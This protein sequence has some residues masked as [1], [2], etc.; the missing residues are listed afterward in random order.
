MTLFIAFC[1]VARTFES[2]KRIDADIAGTKS[3]T[4]ACFTVFCRFVLT[5]DERANV[6]T[7]YI[8]TVAAVNN[9]R[10][11]NSSADR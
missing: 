7:S 9:N 3:L 6:S 1:F 11:I 10:A 5:F 2:S 8:L 4:L